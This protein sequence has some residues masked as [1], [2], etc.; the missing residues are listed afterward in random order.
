MVN[1]YVEVL[2]WGCSS[3]VLLFIDVALLNQDSGLLAS[4]V[5]DK[6][7]AASLTGVPLYMTTSMTFFS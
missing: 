1:T 4:I 2:Y 5:S 3:V 6:K 7:S